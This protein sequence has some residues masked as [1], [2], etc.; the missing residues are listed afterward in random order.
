MYRLA[1]A[2]VSVVDG[3]G[4]VAPVACVNCTMAAVLVAGACPGVVLNGTVTVPVRHGTSVWSNLWLTGPC[5][6][7]VL[8][9]TLTVPGE[10]ADAGVMLLVYNG[11]N[12]SWV[13]SHPFAVGVGVATAL[14]LEG[15]MGDITAGEALAS[16]RMTVV[17]DQG[18]L[19]SPPM[20]EEWAVLV[21]VGRDPSNGR[22][23]VLPALS[24]AAIAG[25]ELQLV[26][27][28]DV[29][30]FF[31][32]PA[33]N[34]TAAGMLIAGGSLLR[35]QDGNCW[36]AWRD[37]DVPSLLEVVAT[38]GH[39][40]S[41]GRPWQEI[42]LA[43]PWRG[44]S[45]NTTAVSQL[46]PGRLQRVV[47]G[48]TW[49]NATS[50]S[51]AGP[52]FTL[53]FTLVNLTCL[54]QHEGWGHLPIARLA[55]L[56]TLQAAPCALLS[57]TTPPF[58]VAPAA[59]AKLA[60]MRQAVGGWA[61]NQP[62]AVQPTVEVQDR[63]GNRV[64]WLQ[65]GLVEA[66]VDAGCAG[67]VVAPPLTGVTAVAVVDGMARFMSLR[68]NTPTVA[69]GCR[70]DVVF[71]AAE[72]GSMVEPARQSRLWVSASA[73]W[74]T[75]A[76]RWPV[77]HPADTMTLSADDYAAPPSLAAWATGAHRPG[78]RFGH[79]VAVDSGFVAVGAPQERSPRPH[80]FYVAALATAAE[81][82]AEEQEVTV[83]AD[84]KP[85]VQR[86][87][88]C[89]PAGAAA[90]GTAPL[91]WRWRAQISRPL[92]LS[93]T[94]DFLA[95]ALQDDL[96]QVA[97]G[98][99]EY[100]W[101]GT[102][103][104]A[105]VP[106]RQMGPNCTGVD[107][108]ITNIVGQEAQLGVEV[109]P[110]PAAAPVT[111]NVSLLRGATQLGGGISL[112]VPLHDDGVPVRTAIAADG[113][114]A[115]V[116]PARFRITRPIPYNAT[117]FQVAAAVSGDLGVGHVDVWDATPAQAPD[118]HLG[119]E[120]WHRI[121]RL[122]F[123]ATLS[124]F[125]V[126]TLVPLAHDL[127]GD[128]AA[129][130]V[131][132]MV[133]GAAPVSG[134]FN[135]SVR[136]GAARSVS[137]A[138]AHDAAAAV[139]AASLNATGL[140]QVATVQRRTLV[141]HTWTGVMWVVTAYPAVPGSDINADP[142]GA[143]VLTQVAW[144]RDVPEAAD[145]WWDG[146]QCAVGCLYGSRAVA[147]VGGGDGA[148]WGSCNALLTDCPCARQPLP[149][150]VLTPLVGAAYL[151]AP[152]HNDSTT[153]SA[154]PMAV[155]ARLQV[156]PAMRQAAATLFGHAVAVA[157]VG[158][159]VHVLVGAPGAGL[160]YSL[161]G[162]MLRCSVNTSD[163]TISQATLVLQVRDWPPLTVP[164]T[165][166]AAALE[167]ALVVGT[168]LQRLRVWPTLG[169]SA[170]L[171]NTTGAATPITWQADA[172]WDAP[173]LPSS[174]SLSPSTSSIAS[175]RA[176]LTPL[177]ATEG[178]SNATYTQAGVVAGAAFLFSA[179]VA[180][181]AAMQQPQELWSW[182]APAGAR[183]GWSVALR[184]SIATGARLVAAVGA[185]GTRVGNASECG[186]VYFYTWGP[187]ATVADSTTRLQQAQRVGCD[188]DY[189]PHPRGQAGAWF[190]AAVALAA[191]GDTVAIGAPGWEGGSG[192]VFV[193]K[194]QPRIGD[195][196]FFDQQLFPVM[197]GGGGFGGSVAFAARVLAVAS[198]R[199]TP[200]N[201]TQAPSGVSVFERVDWGTAGGY[202][203]RVREDGLTGTA[204]TR[205]QVPHLSVAAADGIVLVGCHDDPLESTPGAMFKE[206]YPT[207]R[208]SF[209]VS[210]I[211]LAPA[212]TPVGTVALVQLGFGIAEEPIIHPATSILSP[213]AVRRSVQARWNV[214]GDGVRVPQMVLT[215]PLPVTASALDI[216]DAVEEV[217]SSAQWEVQVEV[218]PRGSE[219]TVTWALSFLPR[220]RQAPASVP[221]TAQ[222][223]LCVEPG[224]VV[225]A[226]D[227]MRPY[228]HDLCV[229]APHGAEN[230]VEQVV[231]SVVTEPL[232][233][234]G[235]S[236]E[237]YALL[238]TTASG[239]ALQIVLPPSRRQMA[240]R[241]GYAVA[242]AVDGWQGVSGCPTR[243][244]SDGYDGAATVAGGVLV[245]DLRLRA[246][247]LTNVHGT[248]SGESGLP[249]LLEGPAPV[250]AIHPITRPRD[251]NV[252]VRVAW[253]LDALPD[254]VAH[255]ELLAVAHVHTGTWTALQNAGDPSLLL[256]ESFDG[257]GDGQCAAAAVQ[258]GQAA[259]AVEL[260]A[261][262]AVAVGLAPGNATNATALTTTL[263]VPDDAVITGSQRTLMHRLQ[264]PGYVAAVQT[265]AV[266]K[267]EVDDDTDGDFAGTY[268][269][270]FARSG[271][272]NVAAAF[273]LEGGTPWV[274]WASPPTAAGSNASLAVGH[275][276]LHGNGT[277][278][279]MPLPLA[280]SVPLAI[281]VHTS[282]HG[283]S[284]SPQS[285]VLNVVVVLSGEDGPVAA[286]RCNA[287][288]SPTPSVTCTP[289]QVLQ[290]QPGVAAEQWLSQHCTH[291]S[292]LRRPLAQVGERAS[293]DAATA[294]V[295]SDGAG[296]LLVAIGLPEWGLVA[297]LRDVNASTAHPSW[298]S[299]AW[300]AA[301]VAQPGGGL[302]WGG[303]TAG[304]RFGHALA[305]DG[306]TL[307]VGAPGMEERYANGSRSRP[308]NRSVT[309]EGTQDPPGAVFV[310]Q[311]EVGDVLDDIF[312]RYSTWLADH[313][314][315]A[316]ANVGASNLNLCQSSESD[317]VWVVHAHLVPSGEQAG[318]FGASVALQGDLLVVGA[319]SQRRAAPWDGS[320]ES[321]A[322]RG[323]TAY[324]SAFVHQPFAC[325]DCDAHYTDAGYRA[326]KTGIRG[327]NVL[328]S[329]RAN[330]RPAALEIPR[331]PTGHA[332]LAPWDGEGWV[333][334]SWDNVTAAYAARVDVTRTGH[335]VSDPFVIRGHYMYLRVRGG[336]RPDVTYI[337]LLVDDAAVITTTGQCSNQTTPHT[338]NVA[339]WM[340]RRARVV[341]VDEDDGVGLGSQMEWAFLEV[342]EITPSWSLQAAAVHGGSVVLFRRAWLQSLVTVDEGINRAT[343]YPHV[344][345]PRRQ[346]DVL[347]TTAAEGAVCDNT[348]VP[349]V[350][351]RPPAF[352]LP[353]C[354]EEG[355]QPLACTWMKTAVVLPRREVTGFGV[356]V[357][358]T[359]GSSL[360]V[361]TSQTNGSS[362]GTVADAFALTAAARGAGVDRELAVVRSDTVDPLLSFSIAWAP[363]QVT[364]AGR[365]SA[366]A[367]SAA[368]SG[369]WITWTS[370]NGALWAPNLAHACLS[371]R[372][373]Q[374]ARAG[375][376]VAATDPLQPY[377]VAE[378][379]SGYP[380]H[381]VMRFG[382]ANATLGSRAAIPVWRCNRGWMTGLDTLVIG[383]RTVDGSAVGSP[384]QAAY[385]ACVQ[386]TS[387]ADV[388]AR[389][390]T[391]LHTTGILHV[392]PNMTHGEVVVPL[393]PAPNIT[394]L[395][396]TARS[397]TFTVQL[398]LVGGWQLVG[399][400]YA[401]TVVVEQQA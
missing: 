145:G 394:L 137:P 170:Q 331:W 2:V 269:T 201:A 327:R 202:L 186:A 27:G 337:A 165:A 287:S 259:G 46:H 67:D 320:F 312:D 322:L 143:E 385:D 227:F 54:Q 295:L 224:P 6:D 22:A 133:Q 323:W 348:T 79:A 233:Q 314:W 199:L 251:H 266:V 70:P 374:V 307:I 123:T 252:T 135:L 69:L 379:V 263:T 13:A 141:G 104:L 339:A 151:V 377:A 317:G 26:N 309:D 260:S 126:P 289:P 47:G 163:P 15:A 282:L 367:T 30:T 162:A 131:S 360:L 240:D 214:S 146:G 53:N 303:G 41:A 277:L 234:L 16:F 189:F 371:F 174:I 195:L 274:A 150:A 33:G 384:S 340:G 311:W 229:Q 203:H 50:V 63:W 92:A 218:V 117:V 354:S 71:Q 194:R 299:S 210:R 347:R 243:S 144:S 399:R 219:D 86:V 124:R 18:T 298:R 294:A 52:L 376:Q 225:S 142:L 180:S 181:P 270:A 321:G 130:T 265:D 400:D 245:H 389:C 300:L 121:W 168:R 24:C 257:S 159:A 14:R 324:G 106:V 175:L 64:T 83:S 236:G 382:A 99:F 368:G 302:R 275:M 11:T 81:L 1:A 8:N 281:A 328:S 114:N 308:A 72:M 109:A 361:V 169:G 118:A 21:T 94:L 278:V 370:A 61:G 256:P 215:R 283:V 207:A 176:A 152:T 356:Q 396:P 12:A 304:T 280:G 74:Q 349:C 17:D 100:G 191:E 365:L 350:P 239:W 134:S 297:V 306:S 381:R 40:A 336:C 153:L 84:W 198:R 316:G 160:P 363:G 355:R 128:G 326:L 49:W 187:D 57:L 341:V 358:L 32:R 9:F 373:E 192:R 28:S 129:V 171:C 93:M 161:A 330:V 380:P 217:T 166:S 386:R 223:T 200:G 82:T 173:G 4:N 391:F 387:L 136:V 7:V 38:V 172:G 37:E 262:D 10:P 301:P 113:R 292:H 335:L 156:P 48:V 397:G 185:P 231:R 209:Q 158:S 334:R 343:S 60:V 319:P 87:V 258:T 98:Q 43:T 164:A 55:V 193:F 138:I 226:W 351:A 244:V 353:G 329:A 101:Q 359:R 232:V 235:A 183:L 364:G 31:P 154:A 346:V 105:A 268:A 286:A 345:T 246:L 35:P 34:D 395:P 149:P 132:T 66:V 107:V 20:N 208:L 179:P 140:L 216:A 148:C 110:S 108:I 318:L 276:P 211:T 51:A 228:W 76:G 116:V 197:D 220:G 19:V 392:L 65:R 267:I 95:V 369:A 188:F 221:L 213:V 344:D 147:V 119:S 56:T 375:V 29:A 127:T 250:A 196:F 253:S 273:A 167:G 357:A 305:A 241:C 23:A 102:V 122:R 296:G 261:C 272:G 366:T 284:S 25:A 390:G 372:R 75:D 103:S 279:S 184:A 80:H 111:L 39:N 205:A 88:T 333:V 206:H 42:R 68:M 212:A 178:S 5:H 62:F 310:F 125:N 238:N 352:L 177:P 264:L 222:Y 383:Y 255:V 89:S 398:S 362:D 182:D 36:P 237:T 288:T 44:A 85:A 204:C 388:P 401:V 291:T 271:V 342:D 393:L 325:P 155:V 73:E 378:P 285:W 91:I 45:D 77:P 115:T 78:D 112:A 96:L 338:W 120:T 315:E 290:L 3:A 230:E 332:G 248:V 242:A 249:H 254:T 157:T 97:G 293:P 313:G 247:R 59:P 58:S 190:G 139:V 90:A